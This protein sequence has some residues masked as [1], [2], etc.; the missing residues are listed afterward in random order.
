M[1]IRPDH[2]AQDRFAKAYEEYSDAIFRHCYFHTFKRE[3]A[4]EIMQETFMKTWEY[5]ASGREIEQVRP[6]LYR[7]ATNLM[8]NASKKKKEQSLDELQETGFDPGVED[9]V[10]KRDIIQEQRV[11]QVL[12]KIEEPYR[13]VVMLRYIEDLTPAEI[14]EITGESANSVS[15]RIHRG[16]KQLRSLLH[17]HG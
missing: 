15:V 9:E 12:E 14:A 4:K 8:I 10:Q 6:F 1:H 17:P 11:L 5:I 3:E 7:T 16:L 2:E 13:Q